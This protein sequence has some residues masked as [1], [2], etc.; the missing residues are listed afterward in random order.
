MKSMPYSEFSIDAAESLLDLAK[1][2]LNEGGQNSEQGRAARADAI[3]HEPPEQKRAA[4]GDEECG[5]EEPEAG[6]LS[7]DA[8]FGDETGIGDQDRD[9]SFV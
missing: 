4:V 5:G 2:R 6:M 8:K 9:V 1:Q 3:Y 7:G